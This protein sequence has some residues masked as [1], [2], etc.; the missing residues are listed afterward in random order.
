MAYSVFAADFK[1]NRKLPNPG[2]TVGIRPQG[3]SGPAAGPAL[4]G[5]PRG[6]RQGFARRRGGLEFGV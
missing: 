4:P 3:S 6:S 5:K 1:A 2:P